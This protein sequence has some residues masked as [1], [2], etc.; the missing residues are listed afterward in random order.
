MD[1][2]NENNTPI[3]AVQFMSW[4]GQLDGVT[5]VDFPTGYLRE[6]GD[7]MDH[8][9]PTPEQHSFPIGM[10]RAI[11]TISPFHKLEIKISGVRIANEKMVWE[12][13][14]QNVTVD[15]IDVDRN[16]WSKVVST[17]KFNGKLDLSV[18]HVA[19]VDITNLLTR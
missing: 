15:K 13:N 9:F 2:K 12:T 7:H 18:E 10:I 19:L 17:R 1:N 8:R 3:T 5:I 16:N 14:E 11:K 6:S 4:L